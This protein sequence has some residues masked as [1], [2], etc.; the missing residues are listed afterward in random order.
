MDWPWRSSA[1]ISPIARPFL[2]GLF[3]LGQM[4]SLV[5]ETPVNSAKELVA[6]ISAAA[7]EIRNTPE[8]LSN[9]RRSMKRRCEA[10]ITCDG[11]QFE[12]LL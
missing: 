8:M 7:G 6:R 9:V 12:H 10:C 5:Y 2:S 3:L 1:L 4:K 11:R